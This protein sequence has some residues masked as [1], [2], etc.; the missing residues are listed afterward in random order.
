[1]VSLK[2]PYECD[3]SS[4]TW[5]C[6]DAK[7]GKFDKLDEIMSLDELMDKFESDCEPEQNCSLS[8][9]VK[10]KAL[11]V[12]ETLMKH[13]FALPFIWPFSSQKMKE[14]RKYLDDVYIN[15]YADKYDN[16]YDIIQEVNEVLNHKDF[17]DLM[18]IQVNGKPFHYTASDLNFMSERLRT[19]FNDLIEKEKINSLPVLITKS[20]HEDEIFQKLKKKYEYVPEAVLLAKSW[21]IK[22][23]A[24]N[25][26]TQSTNSSPPSLMML[27]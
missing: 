15:I 5:K 19:E 8:N 22:F 7:H 18:D 24:L 23:R 10:E 20:E 1:M 2:R 6:S 21:D 27:S 17:G 13:M 26:N 3:F 9:I 16:M 25:Q 4:N 11:K 14:G 12:V